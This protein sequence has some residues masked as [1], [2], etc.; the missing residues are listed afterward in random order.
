MGL[1]VQICRMCE[2]NGDNDGRF[3]SKHRSGGERG[4]KD[5]SQSPGLSS[6]R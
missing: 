4:K 1:G 5:G 2:N 3:R 6:L